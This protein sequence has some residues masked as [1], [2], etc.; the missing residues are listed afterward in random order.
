MDYIDKQFA[1]RGYKLVRQN[2]Y[3]AYYERKDNELNYISE[4]AIIPKTS[5]KYII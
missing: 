5:G 2:E 4:L 1:K 3:G